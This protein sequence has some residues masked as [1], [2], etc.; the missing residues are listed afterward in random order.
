MEK[1]LEH[2]FVKMSHEEFSAY[3]KTEK[4]VTCN[5]LHTNNHNVGD[6]LR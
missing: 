5:K 3:Y 1:F 2:P 6:L 4:V